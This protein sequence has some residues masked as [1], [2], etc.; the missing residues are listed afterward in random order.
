[1]KTS[2]FITVLCMGFLAATPVLGW[3][4]TDP[5]LPDPG[6]ARLSLMG[7]AI[8]SPDELYPVA[9]LEASLGIGSHVALRGPLSLEIAL[10]RPNRQSALLVELGVADLWVSPEGEPYAAWAAVL[11][12]RVGLGAEAAFQLG[13][14]LEGALGKASLN[15][16]LWLSGGAAFFLD[17]GPYATLG[18]GFTYQRLMTGPGATRPVARLGWVGD[19]HIQLLSAPVD[20]QAEQPLLAVHLPIGLDLLGVV[21]VDIDSRTRAATGRYMLG[22]GGVLPAKPTRETSR[23]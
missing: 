3:G 5:A 17:F 4:A 14:G 16:S 18:L 20:G 6:T 8:R 2:T 13:M 7:G 12:G 23:Q 11:G 15:R 10:L 21:T 22:I 9:R 19:A 1:M